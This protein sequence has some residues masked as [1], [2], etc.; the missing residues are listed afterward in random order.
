MHVALWTV[1]LKYVCIFHM[2]SVVCVVY[3]GVASVFCR[4]GGCVCISD[5]FFLC[6][7][8]C[9]LYGVESGTYSSDSATKKQCIDLLTAVGVVLIVSFSL[10]APLPLLLSLLN[11]TDA[12]FFFCF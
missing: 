6:Y 3:V 12:C 9:I 10:V 7:S 5:I 2:S 1:F 8:Y 11:L 4:G